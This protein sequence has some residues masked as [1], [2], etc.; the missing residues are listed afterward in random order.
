MWTS[1]SLHV[2]AELSE[3]VIRLKDVWIYYVFLI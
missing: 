1:Q 2:C 3:E